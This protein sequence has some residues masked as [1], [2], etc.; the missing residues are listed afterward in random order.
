MK[1][2]L[3]YVCLLFS[4]VIGAKHRLMREYVRELIDTRELK[5]HNKNSNF[6]ED[7]R[8]N[9]N[10]ANTTPSDISEGSVLISDDNKLSFVPNFLE[11]DSHLI[12]KKLIAR[13]RYT[14]SLH[15]IGWSRLYVETFDKAAPEI[16]SWA[17][18]FL[19]GKLTARQMLD[20]YKNLVGIH[21][22]ESKYLNEVFNYYTRVEKF[23]RSKTTK[24]S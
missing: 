10:Y 2:L 5:I 1:F 4:I 19:E 15:K 16:L 12:N 18:G 3:K 7:Y 6:L 20:F 11:C 24:E 22:D 13:A 8:F 21:A 9:E 23:I 14:K 17:A